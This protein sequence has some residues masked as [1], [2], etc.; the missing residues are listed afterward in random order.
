M[1]FFTSRESIN[2]IEKVQER[3]LRFVLKDHVSDYNTLLRNSGFDSFR[4]YAVKSLM[5][6]LFKILKGLSPAYLADLFIKSESPYDRRDKN[7]LV[8]L[9]KQTTTYGLRSFQYY[10]AHLWNKLPPHIKSA[11]T[12]SKFKSLIKPWSGPTCSCDLCKA[13]L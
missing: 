7:K 12:V 9:I 13:L 11:D 6:E 8:Q 2:K 1:F 5:I 10:G 4:T 3:A